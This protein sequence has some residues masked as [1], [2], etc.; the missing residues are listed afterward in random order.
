MKVL[1]LGGKDNR[2]TVWNVKPNKKGERTIL[3]TPIYILYG[4]E[5]KIVGLKI[6]ESLSIVISVDKVY[7]ANFN[8]LDRKNSYSFS[9]FWRIFERI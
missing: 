4:H 8:Y 2:I 9:K 6:V 7:S 1:C 5:N 3:K